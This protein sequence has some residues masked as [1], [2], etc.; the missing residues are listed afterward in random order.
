MKTFT[1]S[2]KFNSRN[3][4]E[5]HLK[6][7]SKKSYSSFKLCFSLVYSI[8][9]LK[10][11]GIFRQ[12]G[13]YYELVLN[14]DSL[15]SQKTYL[16]T[17]K[18]QTPRIRSF[19]MSCG[20]EGLFIIDKNDKII[21]SHTNCL[22]FEKEISS[23]IYE[24]NLLKTSMPIIPEPNNVEFKK[25]FVSCKNNFFVDDPKLAEIANY[26]EQIYKNLKINFFSKNGLK[27]IYKKR[28]L[29]NEEYIIN[30]SKK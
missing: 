25:E 26:V 20:P 5:L 11:A 21:D 7:N 6:N 15:T 30:I 24:K 14:E 3:L 28:K 23:P 2:P 22:T 4:L 17:I 10:G 12:T 18:L 8:I 19:N 13:R 1:I 9:S 29:K 16:I 27:I